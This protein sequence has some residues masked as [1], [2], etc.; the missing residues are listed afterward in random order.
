M[1]EFES[2]KN[3]NFFEHGYAAHE[4][5]FSKLECEK[6][7]DEITSCWKISD[8][9]Y[10]HS[11]QYRQHVPLLMTP[12]TVG[13]MQVV[14]SKYQDVFEQFLFNDEMKWLVEF[15][16]ISVSPGARGQIIHRDVADSSKRLITVFVNL[17]DVNLDSGPLLIVSGSQSISGENY[18][19]SSKNLTLQD[20]KPMTLC[21]GSCVLM[22]ARVFHSGTANTSQSLRPVFYFTFGE[23]GVQGPTYS[24]RSEYRGKYKLEDF[25]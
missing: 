25:C 20:L 7:F 14:L 4:A 21:Q 24:I 18:F 17:L 13:V 23:R 2:K 15:S 1:F 8:S 6:I 12:A 10:I 16:S 22:D 19:N 5:L 9:D 11:P 3:S